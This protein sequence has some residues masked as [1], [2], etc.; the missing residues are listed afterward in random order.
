[1][2][3]LAYYK[4]YLTYLPLKRLNILLHVFQLTLRLGVLLFLY[5]QYVNELFVFFKNLDL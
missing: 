5:F 1:M 2:P 3:L 4:L